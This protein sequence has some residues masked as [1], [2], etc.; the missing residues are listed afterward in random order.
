[1]FDLPAWLPEWC[2]E[3]LGGEPVEVL[4]ELR[5]T[6]A[7]QPEAALVGAASGAFANGDSWPP[8]LPPVESSAAFLMTCQKCRGRSGTA[9]ELEV[10]WAASLWTAAHNARWEALHG[11]APAAGDAVRAQAPERLRLAHA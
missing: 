2:R 4:F 6:S 11:A 8:S 5:Q 7:W 1:M 10:A 3:Q 9:D